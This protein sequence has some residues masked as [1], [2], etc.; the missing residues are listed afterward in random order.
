MFVLPGFTSCST[1]FCA[2]LNVLVNIVIDDMPNLLIGLHGILFAGEKTSIKAN[3]LRSYA[4]PTYFFD[5]FHTY[6]VC[7]NPVPG[8]WLACQICP[9]RRTPS[10]L[11]WRARRR[12]PRRRRTARARRGW[13]ARWPGS[14]RSSPASF[15]R[16]REGLMRLCR[17]FL[18][19]I[20]QMISLD[21][22]LFYLV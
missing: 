10:R 17:E 21:S 16:G 4:L 20:K 11:H 12:C 2:F 8:K 18:G 5:V 22:T 1:L 15:R 14:R 3:P 13:G 7:S 19:K 6:Q 9:C